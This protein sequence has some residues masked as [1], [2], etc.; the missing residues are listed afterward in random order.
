M[1]KI[2]IDLGAYTGDT[3]EQFFNW[4]HLL[5]DPKEFE[6]HAFE[7]N[8]KFH[9]KLKILAE[10]KS[11]VTIYPNVA[12]VKDGTIDFVPDNLGSTVMKSKV[13]WDQEKAVQVP[14]IDFSKWLEQFDF[15]DL[16]IVKMDIEGAEFPVL[17]KLLKDRTINLID[18]L[19]VE[20]HPNKVTEYTTTDKNEL[21]E[22]LQRQVP[23]F[24]EWH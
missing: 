10:Q 15:A 20:F 23:N 22:K 16:V 6:I 9:K 7:P 12:W 18:H 2:F 13:N 17:E 11:R 24:W 8:P 21:V 4:G 5:G 19:W 1:K 14:C 3:I